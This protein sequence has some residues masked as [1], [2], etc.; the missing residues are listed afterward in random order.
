MHLMC[1]LAVT[2]LI[3]RCRLRVKKWKNPG[4]ILLDSQSFHNI[5]LSSNWEL[6]L[7]ELDE[8]ENVTSP[9]QVTV[10]LMRFSNSNSPIGDY[11]EITLQSSSFNELKEIV[12]VNV[13]LY[14]FW[15]CTIRKSFICYVLVYSSSMMQ[16]VFHW[17]P[18]NFLGEV[19][20]PTGSGERILNGTLN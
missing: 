16:L 19:S 20:L 11:H 13:I 6:F 15:S 2:K 1:W 7:Q 5:G 10:M 4:K 18:W 14:W 9:S 8:P 17:I 12:S 3:Y